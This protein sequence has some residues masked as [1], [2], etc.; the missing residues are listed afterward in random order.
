MGRNGDF[1]YAICGTAIG[2]FA[3]MREQIL[4][5]IRYHTVHT[6]QIRGFVMR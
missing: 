1:T 3:R 5:T 4:V 6:N 2:R